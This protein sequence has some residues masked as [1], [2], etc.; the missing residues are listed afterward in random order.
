MIIYEGKELMAP[1]EVFKRFN[2]S[3]NTFY[4]LKREGIIKEITI[5]GRNSKFYDS[6][7]MEKIFGLPKKEIKE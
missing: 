4:K 3:R 6:A 1:S 2:I 5:Y 7:E